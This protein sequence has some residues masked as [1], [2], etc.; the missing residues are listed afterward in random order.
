MHELH[1]M[2]GA[3]LS[4]VK[5]AVEMSDLDGYSFTA[6][7][8]VYCSGIGRGGPHLARINTA[9]NELAARRVKST[10]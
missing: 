10:G 6:G 3:R 2:Y 7:P 4:F 1:V 5:K 9:W 8:W